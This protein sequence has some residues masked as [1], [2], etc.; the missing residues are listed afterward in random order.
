[1]LPVLT[2][3]LKREILQKVQLENSEK[4]I[5]LIKEIILGVRF[6]DL[7]MIGQQTKI[8]VWSELSD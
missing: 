4:L 8:I 1:M 7:K 6:K 3:E 2:P 5:W